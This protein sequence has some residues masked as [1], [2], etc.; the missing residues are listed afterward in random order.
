MSVAF[1]C[2]C[3]LGISVCVRMNER[4]TDG[5]R[6]RDGRFEGWFANGRGLRSCPRVRVAQQS[7]RQCPRMGGF[8]SNWCFYDAVACCA[9]KSYKDP[10]RMASFLWRPRYVHSL[11][12]L[13]AIIWARSPQLPESAR[14]ATVG[15][16]VPSDGRL[17]FEL[18]FL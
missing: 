7:V 12:D 6:E 4:E 17:S 14:R 16:P 13:P 2:E 15:A 18:V 11:V 8:L 1:G 10:A 5:S 3:V 9:H